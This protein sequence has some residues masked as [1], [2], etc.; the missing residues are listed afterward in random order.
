MDVSLRVLSQAP[1]LLSSTRQ[2][3]VEHKSLKITPSVKTVLLLGQT[4]FFT[5]K[6]FD[7][8]GVFWQAGFDVDD[9]RGEVLQLWEQ[10][11][12]LYRQLHLYVGRKL[13]EKYG[14]LVPDDPEEPIPAHLFGK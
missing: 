12:P 11:E 4:V 8:M 14:D 10:V 3:K 13:R 1:R 5:C 9:L 2:F 7:D 6:G